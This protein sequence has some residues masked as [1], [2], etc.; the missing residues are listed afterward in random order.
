M[1]AINTYNLPH[2]ILGVQ[3]DLQLSNMFDFEEN[4]KCEV[5]FSKFPWTLLID[6]YVL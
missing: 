6:L 4:E 1:C 5:F 3:N 2:V